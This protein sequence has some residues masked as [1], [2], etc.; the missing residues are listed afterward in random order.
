[1]WR[2]GAITLLAVG[3]HAQGDS[4][5]PCP[6]LPDVFRPMRTPN[7]PGVA[8]ALSA[9]DK[10]LSDAVRRTHALHPLPSAHPLLAV[11]LHKQG[12]DRPTGHHVFL[13]SCLH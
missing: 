7:P 13:P 4:Y 3:A 9:V 11:D 5:G 6:R 8:A 1:M 10:M 12:G 2:V